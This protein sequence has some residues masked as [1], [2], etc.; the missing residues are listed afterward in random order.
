M[1]YFSFSGLVNGLVCTV[2]GA[3]IY[4]Q[5][6]HSRK[7]QIY[8]LYCLSLSI[9]SYFYFLWHLATDYHAA[10]FFSRALMVGA[11][12]IPTLH[13]HHIVTLF[14]METPGRKKWLIFSYGLGIL[15]LIAD[16]TP[17][18]VADVGQKMMIRFWQ[19]PGPLYHPFLI[20]FLIQVFLSNRLLW[21]RWSSASV[22]VKNELRWVALATAIGY[23][24]GC[25]NFF[26]Q[27]D[28]PIPPYLNIL[29]CLY[30]VTAAF[31]F[32]RLGFLDV[33][34]V[35]KH[36]SVV[37]LVYGTLLA[38]TFPAV[39]P[40]ANYF[41]KHSGANP[42]LIFL[43]FGILIGLVLSVGPFIYAYLIRKKI[44]LKGDLTEGLTH[45]LKS[46][47]GIIQSALDRIEENI[48]NSISDSQTLDYL[49]I[50]RNNANRLEQNVSDLLLMAKVQGEDFRIEKEAINLEILLEDILSHHLP[51]A[52][53]KK[54]GLECQSSDVKE[55]YA[56]RDKLNLIISNLISNAIKFSSSGTIKLSVRRNG[57]DVVFSVLDE[58]GGI[59]TDELSKVFDRFYQGKG[60]SKGSGIGL[61]IAKGLVEAHGGR[62]WIYSKGIGQ[63]TCVEFSIPSR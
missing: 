40:L 38:I 24:S 34:Q 21:I 50:V 45:E 51:L 18:F 13:F 62:I 15:F 53:I 19:I 31:L 49:K 42:V 46:P 44:L 9:W 22:L 8:G 35:F 60:S 29:V 4:F 37:L 25:T 2:C 59:P 30:A 16:F 47:L 33:R 41:L 26:L 3:V 48:K 6:R 12:F 1:N 17:Y 61:S 63:G 14:D 52:K 56:D 43:F 5:N 20:L 7:N 54:L 39:L 28:I 55:I 58:G 57:Y 23:S 11:I 36:I 10:L 32:F 27:Y